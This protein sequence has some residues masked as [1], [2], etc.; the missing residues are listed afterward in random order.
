MSNNNYLKVYLGDFNIQAT[1]C[2]I[3]QIFAIRFYGMSS[4]DYWGILQ[5]IMPSFSISQAIAISS[6]LSAIILISLSEYVKYFAINFKET[7]WVKGLS[8]LKW[9]PHRNHIY[10]W[11]LEICPLK[12]QITW[13]FTVAY[14]ILKMMCL[15]WIFCLCYFWLGSVGWGNH[16]LIHA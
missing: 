8:A 9:T 5:N 6:C 10:L 14:M 16:F 2:I 11:Y 13:A 15:S 1:S 3:M 7:P 4:F 12:V